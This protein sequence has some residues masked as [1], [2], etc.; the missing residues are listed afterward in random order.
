M[1][2]PTLSI[3]FHYWSRGFSLIHKRIW[4][5]TER[6]MSYLAFYQKCIPLSGTRIWGMMVAEPPRP[7]T[8]S[9]ADKW[10]QDNVDSDRMVGPVRQ[11]LGIHPALA[12]DIQTFVQIYNV[13]TFL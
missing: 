4:G 6:N 3:T 8:G 13:H 2:T 5:G 12:L 1:E 11:Y 7:S 10:D 9:R